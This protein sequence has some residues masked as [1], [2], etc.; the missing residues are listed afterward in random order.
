M[1][2]VGA[3]ARRGWAL[4]IL[5]MVIGGVVG[6]SFGNS[7]PTTFT[8][9]QRGFVVVNNSGTSGGDAFNAGQAAQARM[10][11]YAALA[12]APAVT[13]RVVSALNVKLSP[14]EIARDL[15]VSFPPGTLVLV[16]KA[17]APTARLASDL[18][19]ETLRQLQTVVEQLETPAPDV[20]QWARLQALSEPADAVASAPVTAKFAAIGLA[21]GAA[22][23]IALAYFY[24]L[25]PE[26][27]GVTAI[28]RRLIHR[29]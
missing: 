1:T 25:I 28:F 6:M 22:A 24:S 13:S 17:T 3:I 19:Q 15:S 7:K 11:S 16:I 29:P 9:T 14:E 8:A 5:L 20:P 26:R 27:W 12:T 2:T 21:I 4:V 10:A 18:A 23:G